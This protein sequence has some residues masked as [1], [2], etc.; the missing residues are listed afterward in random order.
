[1]SSTKS[2]THQDKTNLM[3]RLDKL[4]WSSW[5]T[6]VALSLG[7]GWAMDA[8]ET[9]VA[10]SAISLISSTFQ[11]DDEYQQSLISSVWTFGGMFGALLFGWICDSYGRKSTFMLTLIMYSIGTLITS[12]APNFI[13]FL[14]F[15]GLTSAPV[16]A[17][18]YAVTA[19][20][21]EFVPS[22]YRGP[23]TTL[24]LG[25]WALGSIAATGVNALVLPLVSESIGWRI[26]F[27]LGSVAAVF[28]LWARKK[29]PESPRYLLQKGRIE[30]A[31][32]IVSKIEILAKQPNN[33]L[34][35]NHLTAERRTSSL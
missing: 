24:I 5:H 18:Y 9:Q 19:S 10:A 11:V 12:L 29:L 15:R 1:M 6:Q 34:V 21:A 3:K 17:E 13:F 23:M 28:V 25:L 26:T 4:Q 7:T 33:G 22:K 20:V 30:E 31:E 14:I 27:S 35:I 16:A 8:Y 32:N 2:S